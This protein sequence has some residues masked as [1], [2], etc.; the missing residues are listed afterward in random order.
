M[1]T[2]DYLGDGGRLA[3]GPAD[4]L[5]AAAYVHEIGHG[6]RLAHDQIGRAH[7]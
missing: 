3:G 4:E 2:H 6:P 1:S 5:I 7:V